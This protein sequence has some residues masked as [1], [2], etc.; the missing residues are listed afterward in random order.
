[1]G[2]PYPDI[3]E[4][5]VH[6]LAQHVRS[7]ATNIGNTHK[8][9]TGAINDMGSVYS[10]YCYEQLVTA[11]A[12]MSSGHMAD[13]DTACKVVGKALDI[14]ADVIK[15]VK[16]AVL[17][18]LA[19]LAASYAA[20][21]AAAIATGGFAA[22]MEQMI[23]AAARKLCEAME[24][25]LLSYILSEVVDKAIAPLEHTIDTMI[26]GFLY[27]VASDVL[28]VPSSSSMNAPL[29]IEPDEVKHY[30]DVLDQHADD[31]LQ[32]AQDFANQVAGLDF[33][34]QGGGST[35]VIVD[36]PSAPAASDVAP[37]ESPAKD[38][39]NSSAGDSAR[40]ASAPWTVDTPWDAARR[41]AGEFAAPVSQGH[42][43]DGHGRIHVPDRHDAP[44]GDRTALGNNPVHAHNVHAHN[45]MPQAKGSVPQATGVAPHEAGASAQTTASPQTTVS[46]PEMRNSQPVSPA[47]DDRSAMGPTDTGTT[48]YAPDP[49]ATAS[50]ATSVGAGHTAQFDYPAGSRDADSTAL[51]GGHDQSMPTADPAAAD[52]G[53]GDGPSLPFESAAPQRSS[54]PKRG[55]PDASEAST[56]WMRSPKASARRGT[57]WKKTSRKSRARVIPPTVGRKRSQ[58]TPWTKTERTSQAPK[59]FAPEAESAPRRPDEQA[60]DAAAATSE[61]QSADEAAGGH[62]RATGRRRSDSPG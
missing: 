8:S 44:I 39:L 37:V 36:H 13:L 32:H 17:A 60:S 33:T 58:Q 4:D 59:V 50:P 22:A 56:P 57:P 31:I 38:W 1:M 10:G 47:A 26:H 23:A 43:V 54:S 53:S 29:Y 41:G 49:T 62:T 14:A 7:F 25:A 51:R 27:G 40:T 9:A 42:P 19:G 3:N 5:H 35:P 2:I 46:G 30:A 12:R 45:P 28:G 55:R 11:W 16:I 15:A 61:N 20:M 34:T 52:P 48:S 18:E 6:A 21:M 24:Q